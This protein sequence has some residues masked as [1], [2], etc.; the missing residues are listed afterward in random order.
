MYSSASLN[1][2]T[3]L[4][5]SS[6]ELSLL[7]KPKL[8]T[9]QT[10]AP[11][12][13]YLQPLEHEA[14][15]PPLVHIFLYIWAFGVVVRGRQRIPV[16]PARRKRDS[17]KGVFCWGLVLSDSRISPRRLF[18]FL[19]VACPTAAENSSAVSLRGQG[20]LTRLAG[21]AVTGGVYAAPW[22]SVQ[23]EFSPPNYAFSF[24][25]IFMFWIEVFQSGPNPNA[26]YFW[27]NLNWSHWVVLKISKQGKS[28]VLFFFYFI[29]FILLH[30]GLGI[31]N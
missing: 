6:L 1:I 4:C 11:P 14:C 25:L 20:S 9:H 23:P 19:P 15:S 7:A 5:D 26:E 3:P 30:P 16:S 18:V 17:D 29:F 22:N 10:T 21:V 13:P 31:G 27:K 8:S 28:D 2:F 12:P 24:F